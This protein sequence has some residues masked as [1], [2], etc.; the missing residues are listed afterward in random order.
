[1]YKRIWGIMMAMIL[2]FTSIDLSVVAM[3]K[4]SVTEDI[5]T[6]ESIGDDKEIIEEE[7]GMR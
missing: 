7:G 6:M 2:V 5:D 4:E 3:E 1:M